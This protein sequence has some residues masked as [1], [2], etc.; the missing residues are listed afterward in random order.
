M[1]LTRAILLDN[2]FNNF[3]YLDRIFNI[4]QFKI[5]LFYMHID[6]KLYITI[7]YLIIVLSRKDENRF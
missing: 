6:L 1:F 4:L 2:S 5:D 3:N 7:R